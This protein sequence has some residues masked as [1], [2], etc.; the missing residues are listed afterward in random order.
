MNVSLVDDSSIQIDLQDLFHQLSDESLKKLATIYAWESPAW[1]A[2]I[3]EVRSE[4]ATRSFNSDLYYL[5]RTFFGMPLDSSDESLTSDEESEIVKVMSQTF[6]SLLEEVSY[7]VTEGDKYR[8]A[9]YSISDYL[10]ERFGPDAAYHFRKY[11]VDLP[12]IDSLQVSRKV[13]SDISKMTQDTIDEWS[14]TLIRIMKRVLNA[15]PQE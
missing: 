10:S 9:Y 13:S 5:R 6:S 15:T 14:Q 3:Q 1:R 7:R 4:F 2:I 8:R 12:D 11:V